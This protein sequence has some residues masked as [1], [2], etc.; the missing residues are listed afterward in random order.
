MS[1]RRRIFFS[2][3]DASFLFI[4][5]FRVISNMKINFVIRR[6]DFLEDTE[7][8][9]TV[10]L[11]GTGPEISIITLLALRGGKNQDKKRRSAIY[12]EFK[13]FHTFWQGS[14]V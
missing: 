9:K 7:A 1:S 12:F 10:N 3:L 8:Q 4:L 11:S 14:H 5:C 6:Q 13:I 2:R